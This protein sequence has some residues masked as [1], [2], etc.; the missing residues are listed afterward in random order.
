MVTE[1]WFRAEREDRALY[2]GAD[3]VDRIRLIRRGDGRDPDV[4]P[5]ADVGMV[6]VLSLDDAQVLLDSLAQAVCASPESDRLKQLEQVAAQMTGVLREIDAADLFPSGLVGES[7]A[8][9]VHTA[10]A[11][12]DAYNK[13]RNDG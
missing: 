11:S 1:P 3:D 10:L 13:G 7:L 4:D 8:D 6:Y 5:W 9:Q 2:P 12:F